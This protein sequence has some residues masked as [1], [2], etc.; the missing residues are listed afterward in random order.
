MAGLILAGMAAAG[1][2]GVQSINQNIDQANRLDLLHQQ[3][4]LDLQKAQTLAKFHSDLE[5]EGAERARTDQTARIGAAREGIIQGQLAAQY[6]GSDSAVAAADAGKTDM[7]VTDAQ[8][9]VI[10]Q[11]K[12]QTA[13]EL[14]A[15]PDTYVKAAIQTGDIAPKDVMT[16][17]AKEQEREMRTLIAQGRYDTAIQVAQMKGDFATLIAQA[18]IAGGS[19]DRVVGHMAVNTIEHDIKNNDFLYAQ[20]HKDFAEAKKTMD[21]DGAKEARATMDRL[22]AENDGLKHQRITLIGHL[23]VDMSESPGTPVGFPKVSPSEQQ[24]RDETRYK[25]LQDELKASPNDTALQQEIAAMDAKR[26]GKRPAPQAA[27]PATVAAP[28]P[29]QR[30]W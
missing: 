14:R 2:S 19:T 3:S 20:A 4:D 13:A 30:T 8:R 28:K 12:A 24:G 1:D 25:M 29:W 11:A 9:A 17:S 18:K 26:P 15:S 21:E 27:A 6:G 23:G 5:A 7:S 10:E 22:L 16:N